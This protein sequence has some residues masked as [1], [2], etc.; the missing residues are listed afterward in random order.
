[1]SQPLSAPPAVMGAGQAAE[2]LGVSHRTVIRLIHAGRISA[3]RTGPGTAGFAIAAAE[4][5]RVAAERARAS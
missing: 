3:T 1:M 2:R 4:V 5:E